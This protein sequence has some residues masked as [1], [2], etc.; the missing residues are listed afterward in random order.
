MLET[1]TDWK[2]HR[3]LDE[4]RR[5]YI[6]PARGS[7]KSQIEQLFD[8]ID[9][10]KDVYVMT[11]ADIPKRIPSMEQIKETI[12]D[13]DLQDVP[14][15]CAGFQDEFWEGLKAHYRLDNPCDEDRH[16]WIRTVNPYGYS[17]FI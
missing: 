14:S 3:K 9:S 11:K 13:W 6:Y 2:I 10:G 7:G 8:L 5:I 12:L 15:W 1:Y 17:W 16:M 4:A